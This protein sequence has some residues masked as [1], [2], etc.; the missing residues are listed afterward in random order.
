M[1]AYKQTERRAL[2][3]TAAGRGAA[4][5]HTDPQCKPEI[6]HIKED[7]AKQIRLI[8]PLVLLEKS[9]DWLF[10]KYPDVQLFNC[11][12]SQNK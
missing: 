7:A 9:S 6:F 2:Y 5:T 4:C 10:S 1:H 3:M 8:P 12:C 11:A